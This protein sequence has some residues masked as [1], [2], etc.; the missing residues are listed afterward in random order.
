MINYEQRDTLLTTSELARLLNVHASTVRRWSN[1]GK[2]KAY[3]VGQRGEKRF[4]W[5][6]VAV[7]FSERVAQKYLK[8]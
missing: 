6:D 2:I 7:F 8:S 5:N 4:Q 1:C 3:R